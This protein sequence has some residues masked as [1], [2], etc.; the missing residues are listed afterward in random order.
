MNVTQRHTFQKPILTGIVLM[1][2]ALSFRLVDIF[3]LRLDERLGEIILSKAL[4]FCL[5]LLFVWAIGKKLSSIGFHGR[6]L[7][8]SLLIGTVITVL[9]FII[10]YTVEWLL[11]Q[12]LGQEPRCFLP[13]IPR[14]VS[15]GGGEL[16]TGRPSFSPLGELGCRFIWQRMSDEEP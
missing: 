1:L 3:V 15:Q 9:P 8:E 6:K 5:V 13:L 4:G 2:I 14:Q 11:L 12:Q 16:Q 10:A 7:G